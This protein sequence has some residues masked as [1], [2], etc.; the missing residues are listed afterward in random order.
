MTFMIFTLCLLSCSF[1]FLVASFN[2]T[3]QNGGL[4]ATM[5]VMLT[6]LLAGRFVE[7][8]KGGM[9]EKLSYIFPQRYMIDYAIQ[10]ENNTTKNILPMIIIVLTSVI[11]IIL[12]GIKNKR[13]MNL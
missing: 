8:A 3:E 7:I 2:R 12:G 5:T 13:R 4:V 6:S 1:N 11:L 10:A 9:A